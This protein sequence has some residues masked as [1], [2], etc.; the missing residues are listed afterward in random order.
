ML[1]RHRLAIMLLLTAFYVSAQPV[2]PDFSLWSSTVLPPLSLSSSELDTSINSNRAGVFFLDSDRVVVYGVLHDPHQLSSRATPE[3]SSPFRLHVWILDAESGQV[4]STKE[5]GT[6]LH[7]SAVH[8]VVGGILVKTGTI[9]NVFSKDFSS[10]TALTLNVAPD[11]ELDAKVSPSGKTIL[12]E[13][14]N[15]RDNLSRM[16]IIDGETLR[17]RSSWKQSPPLFHSYS[18]SDETIA[19]VDFANHSIVTSRF[20]STTWKK[21]GDPSG[22]CWSMNT[23]VLVSNSIV[24]GCDKLIRVGDDGSTQLTEA[25]AAN[26]SP[27]GGAVV[28]Q[29]TSVVAVPLQTISIARHFLSESTRKVIERD[30]VVYDVQGM[31]R[32]STINIEPLPMF[33]LSVALSPDGSKI[34]VLDDRRVT[35][36]RVS[37]Q[38]TK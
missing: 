5:W 21:V 17:V 11:E 26:Q 14:I 2:R 18:I 4:I 19:A 35:L 27:S 6:R 10:K 25:F 8:G 20:G 28:A 16:W 24:Y 29:K 31:R 32:L 15:Q 23:P 33:S 7:D 1:M 37:Q 38:T 36:Y 9:V 30:I 13:V 3:S 22:L 12:L 34:A